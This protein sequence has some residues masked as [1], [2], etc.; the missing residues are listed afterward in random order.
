MLSKAKELVPGK[1]ATNSSRNSLDET[2]HRSKNA[3][4]SRRRSKHTKGP[5]LP[6]K[7]TNTEGQEE[8][9][10]VRAAVAN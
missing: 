3:L 5:S 7:M 9:N 4:T 1:S 2:Q 10:C 6:L 8:R